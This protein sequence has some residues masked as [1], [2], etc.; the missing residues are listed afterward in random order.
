MISRR[1]TKDGSFTL[2]SEQYKQTFHSINGIK[3]DIKNDIKTE[4][5]H[6]FSRHQV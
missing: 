4:A 3:N 2:Y 6:V 1:L 5:D